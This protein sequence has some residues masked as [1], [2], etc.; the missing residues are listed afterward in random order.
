[1]KKKYYKKKEE[2]IKKYIFE[3]EIN[4]NYYNLRGINWKMIMISMA[5]YCVD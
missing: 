3:I 4:I 2:Y 5:I 1:M